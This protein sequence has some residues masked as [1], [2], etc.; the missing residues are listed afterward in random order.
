MYVEQLLKCPSSLILVDLGPRIKEVGADTFRAVV[1]DYQVWLDFP[2]EFSCFHERF[3]FHL[4]VLPPIYTNRAVLAV[5]AVGSPVKEE[6]YAIEGR[7]TIIAQ[8]VRHARKCGVVVVVAAK[9]LVFFWI[10]II[11]RI[12][13]KTEVTDL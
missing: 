3:D 6:L 11:Q 10:Y 2:I 4:L 8:I 5:Y 12:V 1:R 7:I 13:F 9:Y